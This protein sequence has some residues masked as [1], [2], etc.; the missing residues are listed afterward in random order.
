MPDKSARQSPSRTSSKEKRAI[1][2]S[3]KA[4]AE[5]ERIVVFLRSGPTADQCSE[6]VR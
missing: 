6:K 2:R 1:K 3:R 4:T 5:N